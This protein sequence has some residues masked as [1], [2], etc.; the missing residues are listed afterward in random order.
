[1]NTVHLWIFEF[2]YE[3]FHIGEAYEDQKK[4]RTVAAYQTIFRKNTQRILLFFLPSVSDHV[5]I[6]PREKLA[7]ARACK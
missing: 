4:L 1:M 2:N 7:S 6:I 3:S 5:F